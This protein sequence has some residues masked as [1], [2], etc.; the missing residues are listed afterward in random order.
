MN[1]PEMFLFLER[2]IQQYKIV[3]GQA[4]DVVLD[5]DVS[6]FPVFVMH[7]QQLELGIPIAEKGKVKGNWSVHVS[8]LEEFVSKQIINPENIEKFKKDYKDPKQHLCVFVLSE[9]GA[10]FIHVPR[11]N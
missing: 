1:K 8:S 6:K 4:T 2:E 10:Q 3:M 9:L 7:Q 5:S 11:K